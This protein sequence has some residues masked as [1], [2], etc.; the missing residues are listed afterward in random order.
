MSVRKCKF[1]QLQ[2]KYTCKTHN[3]YF[4]AEHYTEHICDGNSHIPFKIDNALNQSNFNQLQN[5][6]NERIKALKCA[7]KQVI[8]KSAQL[9]ANIEQMCI[10]SIQKLDAQIQFYLA[11]IA[12]NNFDQQKLENISKILT[13]RLEISIDQQFTLNLREL[14][15]EEQKI[16]IQNEE[17]LRD[18]K[19]KQQQ[20]QISSNEIKRKCSK[21]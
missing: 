4:C 16:P 14:T 12:D 20:K 21:P 3:E 2:A 6:V 15:R 19:F 11:Y 10:S 9:I 1:D 18:E 17:Q 7:K 8:S 5:E 13:T